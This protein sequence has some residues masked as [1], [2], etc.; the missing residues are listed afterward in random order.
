MFGSLE[1]LLREVVAKLGEIVQL[2]KEVKVLLE[3]QR[4]KK[5]GDRSHS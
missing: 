1:K 3:E 5:T 4:N 2:L